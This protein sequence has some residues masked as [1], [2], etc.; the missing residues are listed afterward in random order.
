MGAGR[1]PEGRGRLG[2]SVVGRR[3]TR[4]TVVRDSGL[5]TSAGSIRWECVCDCGN[6]C[7]AV[8]AALERGEYRSCGCWTKDRM[9][10]SPPAKTHGMSSSPTYRTWA[11]MKRRCLD[12]G[13]K[14]YPEYGG[15]GIRVS[16]KWRTFRGFLADMGERPEGMTLDRIDSNGHY[17]AGNCRWATRLTQSNNT[18]RNHTLTH[19]G[20][21]LTLAEWSRKT[22]IPYSRLRARINLLGWPVGKALDREK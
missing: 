9:R 19:D 5:R 12:P 1:R 20:E 14:D 3:F 2:G 17:T 13:F 22:G 7:Y 16:R 18:R 10:T 21:T 11:V 15:R 6:T 8:A 4:L